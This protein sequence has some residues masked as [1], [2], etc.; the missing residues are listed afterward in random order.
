MKKEI[1][2]LV[3][4]G[5]GFIGCNMIAFLKKKGFYARCVDVKISERNKQRGIM[6]NQADEVLKLDLREQANADKAVKGMDWVFHFAS[7]MGG[8]GYFHSRNFYP[9]INNMQI[10]LNMLRAAEKFNVRRFFYSSS[11]CIYPTSLQMVESEAIRLSEEMKYPA[12]PDQNYGWEKL[13]MLRLCE[14]APFDA[15]V[16]IFN[17]IY[18]LYQEIEGERMK[19]PTAI[20]TK[21][22]KSKLN[23]KPIEVWGNGKQIRSFLYIDD[24][25]ERAYRIMTMP[26]KGPV[27]VSAEESITV[28]ETARML[29]EI[30]GIKPRFKFN[31]NKPSGVLARAIDNTKFNKIYKYKDKVS[32]R[33]GFTR[34]YNWVETE[35]KNTK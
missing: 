2:V 26:Y 35:Q 11:V 14:E 6:F 34:L 13:L 25:C 5:T 28:E 31:Q 20:A 3:T 15:R 33:E 12:F 21:V 17:T 24:L 22:L 4:G 16:G 8:V 7:D 32:L 29:C 27:N 23:G 9:I 1:K 18:G 10:D 19:F 30:A